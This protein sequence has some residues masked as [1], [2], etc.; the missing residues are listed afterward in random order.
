MKLSPPLTSLA[1]IFQ[2]PLRAPPILSIAFAQNLPNVKHRF[3]TSAPTFARQSQRPKVDKRITLIRYHLQHPLT[4]RP[5]RFSRLRY[6]RHWTIHR[7][8]Q[9]YLHTERRRVEQELER[10]YNSMR[11]ACEELRV[12]V[13]DGG[14]LY[15]QATT[16]K[17]LFGGVK[18][19]GEVVGNG[20]V[21]I[22]YARAQVEGPGRDGWDHGWT[23]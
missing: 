4:P 18:M 11:A 9:L 7:A 8:F 13:G 3:S 16:R 17:G 15:R 12:G 19:E 14:R 6:L 2:I 20:G 23:R 5:L 21:P 22:E 10:Q 1:S